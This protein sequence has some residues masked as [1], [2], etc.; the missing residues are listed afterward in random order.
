MKP[1]FLHA[2]CCKE[3]SSFFGTEKLR[4]MLGSNMLFRDLTNT[5]MIYSE[6]D[7]E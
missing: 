5:L 7:L 3:Q 2:S 1:G 6:T 4:G